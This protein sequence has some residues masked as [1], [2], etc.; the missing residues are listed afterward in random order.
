MLRILNSQSREKEEFKPLDPAGRKVRIYCCGP[1]V[2][3]SLHIG[4]ARAYIVPDVIRRYLE[5]KGYQVRYV[6]N[7]TDIDD[8]IIKRALKEKRSWREITDTYIGESHALMHRLN[9][10]PADGFPRATDHIDEMLEI[11]KL[12]MDRK[13][14]YAASDGDIYFDTGSYAR[15]G[16]LSKR[17][18]D[19]EEAGLSG[20]VDEERL[21]VKKNPGDFILWKLNKNDKG[22]L[23]AGGD[24]VPRWPSPYGD[25]RP[26]WHL[27]CSA[28]SRRYLGVPFDIHCGGKDLLF[29]H[30]EDEKA[31]TECAYC[32]ELSGAESV[33]Y[34]VH[35]EFITVDGEKMAKSSQEKMGRSNVKWVRE[36]IWPEGP[37]DPMALRMMLLS[38]HYRS[39]VDFSLEMLDEATAKLERIYNALEGL[40]RISGENPN[41]TGSWRKTSE[42]MA[43]LEDAGTQTIGVPLLKAVV[44]AESAF[45]S[46]MDDDFNTAGALGVIFE[47]VSAVNS[48]LAKRAGQ[49]C[50]PAERI[51][52]QHASQTIRKLLGILGLREWRETLSGGAEAGLSA[53]LLEIRALARQGKQFP[54][55]DAIRDGLLKLNFEIKDLPGG[56]SEV[57]KK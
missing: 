20:R 12:L 56:K 9:I 17:K 46:S 40:A 28:M 13:H 31:Q 55:A 21:K 24:K 29:P 5:H 51:G 50:S 53:L 37:Y 18:L 34:W 1:T 7:F 36:M 39:P 2:Y 3:D 4:H 35:N 15:Y 8:K 41:E 27:E 47:L 57:R 48:E 42:E 16:N 54:L 43:L 32:D 11:V 33:R 22:E 10:R 49:E 23:Q 44:R 6:T 26:G 38:S 19:E 45:E 25:G 30:H 14:A 52:F